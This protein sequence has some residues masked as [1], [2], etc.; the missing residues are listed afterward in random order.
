MVFSAS[1]S[2]FPMK[3]NLRPTIN[4]E[5]IALAC[6]SY[7]VKLSRLARREIDLS[8][9]ELCSKAYKDSS[10]LRSQCELLMDRALHLKPP[11]KPDSRL[12]KQL[13]NLIAVSE[14]LENAFMESLDRSGRFVYRQRIINNENNKNNK[15]KSPEYTCD[16]NDNDKEGEGCA[17]CCTTEDSSWGPALTCCDRHQTEIL[18][19][20]ECYNRLERCPYCR[21]QISN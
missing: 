15:N 19:C 16:N 5:R 4:K 3:Y 10:D 17:I 21:A 11:I 9:Y 18:I 2:F 8:D 6:M 13:I 1:M 7:I 20:R 14:S 12:A